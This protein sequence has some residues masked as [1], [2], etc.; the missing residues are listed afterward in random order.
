[1]MD[2]P[3]LSSASVTEA[4][5]GIFMI[6]ERVALREIRPPVNCYLIAGENGL[7]FD[8]GYGTSSAVRSFVHK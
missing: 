4:A 5:P 8:A 3:R 7:A 2:L 6:T 1:M